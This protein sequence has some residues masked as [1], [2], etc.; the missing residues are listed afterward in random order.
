MLRGSIGSA[1]VAVATVVLTTLLVVAAAPPRGPSIRFDEMTHDFGTI[2]SDQPVEYDWPFR[3]EGDAPLLIVRTRPQ[4]G[5]TATVLDDEPVPPGESGTMKVTFDP[6]GLEGG[7]R[8][9]LAVMSDDPRKP[10][11]LLTL[12][13]EVIPIEVPREDGEHPRIAGQSLLVGECAGCHAAPAAGKSGAELYAAVC[14]T[15]HGED[16][17]GVHAPSIR[18][19]SYLAARTDEELQQAISYGSANPRMPGFLDLMG[20]PL[21]GAQVESLVRLMRSWDVEGASPTR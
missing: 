14:A 8:K 11:V 6:I 20:G 18:D 16:G 3:N 4:C 10:H 1:V 13:A 15:C 5:C 17:G 21:D 12:V 7:V 9:S 19:P 2:R